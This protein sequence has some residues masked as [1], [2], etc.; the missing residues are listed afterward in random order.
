MNRLF[1][2]LILFLG[3]TEVNGQVYQQDQI[4]AAQAALAESGVEQDEVKRRLR[5]KVIDL[6]NIQPDQLSTLEAEIRS[7]VKEIQ[8]EQE[9]EEAASDDDASSDQGSDDQASGPDQETV[10]SSKVQP[11]QEF[12]EPIK[13]LTSDSIE[14]EA[15]QKM[16]MLSRKSADEVIRR[17][18]QGATL[19]EAIYDVLTEE[20]QN[21]Y[22]AQSS[23]Y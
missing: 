13:D 22:S 3:I 16:Q 17:M 20:E 8:Q 21:Q 2:I 11:S 7:V 23:V 6:D 15:K 1:L 4:E 14:A 9:D 19:D 18:K 5:A 12:N 10:V